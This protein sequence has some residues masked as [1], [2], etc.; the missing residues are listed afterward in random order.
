MIQKKL[1]RT[2]VFFVLAISIMVLAAIC[3]AKKSPWGDPKS[4][5]ILT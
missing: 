4:G 5:L 1:K 2:R 3:A